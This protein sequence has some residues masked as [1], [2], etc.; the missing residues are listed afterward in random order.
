L[1]E[2]TSAV[3]KPGTEIIT[4]RQKAPFCTYS[5]PFLMSPL[6]PLCNAGHVLTPEF[7]ILDA[8]GATYAARYPLYVPPSRF[9]SHPIGLCTLP[10]REL[11]IDY[12][13]L[14]ICLI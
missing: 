12:L 8:R 6:P 9:T 3:I 1:S 7:W 10:P 2:P 4:S 5:H 14:S 11:M 13:T